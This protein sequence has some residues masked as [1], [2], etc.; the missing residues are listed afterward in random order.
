MVWRLV[1]CFSRLRVLRRSEARRQTLLL[2][3]SWADMR[4]RPM[5]VIRTFRHLRERLINWMKHPRRINMHSLDYQQPRPSWRNAK[6]VCGNG[7]EVLQDRKSISEK[8]KRGQFRMLH[9]IVFQLSSCMNS[10]AYFFFQASEDG[11]RIQRQLAN[12]RTA[13]LGLQRETT[14][15]I[16]EIERQWLNA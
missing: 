7:K 15:W 10:Y 5:R 1:E 9:R 11:K 12:L 16:S 2:N 4:L 13:F 8:R 6:Q 3:S 14:S